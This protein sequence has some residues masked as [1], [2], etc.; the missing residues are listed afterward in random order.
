MVASSK[1]QEEAQPPPPPK[2]QG[3][4]LLFFSWHQHKILL[5]LMLFGSAINLNYIRKTLLQLIPPE[6]RIDFPPEGR[7]DISININVDRNAVAS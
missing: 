3:V 2:F 4:F 5:T 1:Q 7:I 6:D